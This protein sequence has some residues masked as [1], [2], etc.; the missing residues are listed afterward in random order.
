MTYPYQATVSG[1]SIKITGMDADGKYLF[2]GGEKLWIKPLKREPFRALTLKN[3]SKLTFTGGE[4]VLDGENVKNRY[5]AAAV[6]SRETNGE[7]HTEEQT[8]FRLLE[9]LKMLS[10]EDRDKRKG[11]AWFDEHFA[12]VEGETAE[13][14]AVLQDSLDSIHGVGKFDVKPPLPPAKGFRPVLLADYQIVNRPQ[15][16]TGQRDKSD[17][18]YFTSIKQAAAYAKKTERTIL[19]W[20]Q[21]SWLKVEQVGKKVRIAKTELDKCIVKL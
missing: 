15:A 13:D 20:K 17:P 16:G 18:A 8:T 12:Q 1:K 7:A 19:N 21:R 3:I 10:H 14:C 9:V 2:D 5:Y 4:W 11:V 6:T